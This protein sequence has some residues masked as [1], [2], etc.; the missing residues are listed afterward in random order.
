MII[1]VDSEAVMLSS[2]VHT[3]FDFYL[4]QTTVAITVIRPCFIVVGCIVMWDIIYI[5]DEIGPYGYFI[6]SVGDI[7]IELAVISAA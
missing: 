4:F 6:F 2:R 7:Q 5:F 1:Y 3:F